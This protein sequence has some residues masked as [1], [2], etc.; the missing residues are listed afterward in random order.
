MQLPSVLCPENS[1]RV[2]FYCPGSSNLPTPFSTIIYKPW[3]EGCV[4]QTF[5]L[6]LSTP[7]SLNLYMLA[8]VCMSGLIVVYFKKCGKRGHFSKQCEQKRAINQPHYNTTPSNISPK[9]KK[10]FHWACQCQSGTREKSDPVLG[11]GRMSAAGPLTLLAWSLSVWTSA[12]LQQDTA[13]FARLRLCPA[14]CHPDPFLTPT[15]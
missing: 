7:Q 15:Q 4:I 2:V 13:W 11:T 5:H 10:C 8:N 9:C 12:V 1:F 6:G 14:A 3:K